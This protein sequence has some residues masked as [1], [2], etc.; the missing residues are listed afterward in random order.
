MKKFYLFIIEMV[1]VTGLCAQSTFH[2]SLGIPNN[3]GSLYRSQRTTDGGFVSVGRVS[4]NAVSDNDFL[5][6]K[7]DA[8]GNG[9]W[10]KRYST[11]DFEEFTDVI[12]VAGGGL[13]AVGT[14]TNMGTFI[15]GAVVKKI[16]AAGVGLWTKTY[17]VSGHSAGARM[18]QKD[19]AGNLYILGSVSVDGSSDDYLIMK[20]DANGNILTQATFGTPDYDYPLAFVR[21]GNG[22]LFI[23]GWDNTMS[24]ENIHLLKVN[25]NMTLAWNRKISGT[26]RYF[27]YDMKERADGNLV[28]AG[29][30]DDGGSSYDILI[31]TMDAST[32]DQV[33]A[34]SYSSADD[35]GTYAYGVTVA[36]GDVIAVTGPAETAG[37]GTFLLGTDATG[38]L[39]W[40]YR[41]GEPGSTGEGYGVT[42]ASDGG[43]LVCGLYSNSSD[44]IV[45]LLKTNSAGYLA[46][47]SA[48][49]ELTV[50]SIT[51][52][53]QTLSV[54]T[55]TTSLTAQD[56]IL[57]ET[58]YSNLATICLGTGT[59]EVTA[60]AFTI[61]P[62]PSN[63]R[64][65]VTVP[66]TYA[67]ATV[68][69]VNNAGEELLR[70]SMPSG[71]GMTSVSKSFET[72]APGGIY[73]VKVDDGRET[74]VRKLCIVGK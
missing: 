9:S 50:T 73:V 14:S 64:F 24:G 44:A 51:L 70:E 36:S 21:K 46:C 48:A 68:M 1:L 56:L 13:V 32:G 62:N 41:Y 12:E 11:A 57:T 63:G 60:S 25:A 2:K 43:Y 22:D 20:L 72:G 54:T 33:W 5:I 7:T 49:Y 74:V 19:D 37:Q 42:T 47:N 30:Y 3:G 69:L 31:C 66:G 18:I 28:L 45:Q 27:A 4:D 59:P 17:S 52:P 53:I 65:T 71:N 10:I 26:T 6:M 8:A 38:N 61:S 55:G 39:T 29:R 15:S 58:P 23:C 16:D 67:G 35:F 34:K 40:S